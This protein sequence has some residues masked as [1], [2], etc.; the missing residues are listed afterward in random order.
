M[1]SRFEATAGSPCDVGFQQPP[2]VGAERPGPGRFS[3]TPLVG[4]GR[5]IREQ[6]WLP[7]AKNG[8]LPLATVRGDN[9]LRLPVPCP[10]PDTVVLIPSTGYLAFPSTKLVVER[11]FCKKQN[12]SAFYAIAVSPNLP[13][14]DIRQRGVRTP[15][16][17]ISFSPPLT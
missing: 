4:F 14:P 7:L 13:T 5:P 2:L 15:G 6:T 17:S 8:G 1:K 10:R 12:A 9:P 3:A 16:S 11:S